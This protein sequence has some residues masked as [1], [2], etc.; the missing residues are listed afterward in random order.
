MRNS[1]EQQRQQAEITFQSHNQYSGPLPKP[2][3]LAKYEQVIPGAA[4]RIIKMAEREMQHRH[5]YETR[6]SKGIVLTTILAIV[7][8]F[9]CALLLCSIVF[10]SIHK[11]AYTAAA[12][13]SVGT[14]AAVIG[15]FMTSRL[16]KK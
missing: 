5:E 8:A 10:Y 11:G 2:E 6:S 9:I 14:I 7:F 16:K 13:I 12:S 15:A 3:D 1:K 4:E